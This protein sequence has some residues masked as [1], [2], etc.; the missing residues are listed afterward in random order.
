MGFD[1]EIRITEWIRTGHNKIPGGKYGD[2][3]ISEV[4][5]EDLIAE[6]TKRYGRVLEIT[7]QEELYTMVGDKLD[8]KELAALCESREKIRRSKMGI[9]NGEPRDKNMEK[10]IDALLEGPREAYNKFSDLGV[11]AV[12]Y[13]ISKLEG[14]GVVF[15][16]GDALEHIGVAAIP[17]IVSALE[18]NNIKSGLGDLGYFVI[19]MT[20]G[21]MLPCAQ[22]EVMPALEFIVRRSKDHEAREKVV[23]VLKENFH[24]LK[25]EN[26]QKSLA[27]F[28]FAAE[29]KS[30]CVRCDAVEALGEIMYFRP[31]EIVSALK[32]RIQKDRDW[33]VR[34]SAIDA[35]V[36]V[37][38]L[39]PGNILS[40]RENVREILQGI[41]IALKGRNMEVLRHAVIALGRLKNSSEKGEVTDLIISAALNT[42]FSSHV[43]RYAIG[44]LAEIPSM[45]EKIIPVLTR[46][47]EQDKNSEVRD[48]AACS[49]KEIQSRE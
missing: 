31:E 27:I 26:K 43:R 18:N 20:L 11:K 24:Y 29:D 37:S 15:S 28:K 48:S 22:D 13:L 44:D 30:Y 45:K 42:R 38:N 10:E 32:N 49:L 16:A 36:G 41:E 47:S 21:K 4:N 1:N 6:L 25:E 12:P 2:I 35:L 3:D 14:S 5:K 46:L 9:F 23:C 7:E 33:Q 34:C 40:R 19:A 39:E 17:G 8:K